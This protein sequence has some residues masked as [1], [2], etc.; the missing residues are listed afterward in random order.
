[1]SHTRR[2]PHVGEQDFIAR[3]VQ[4][5]ESLRDR[6]HIDVLGEQFATGEIS[7]VVDNRGI[8]ILFEEDL[9]DSDASILD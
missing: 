2:E 3:I 9:G 1:M 5:F 7:F 4:G 8:R 6:P